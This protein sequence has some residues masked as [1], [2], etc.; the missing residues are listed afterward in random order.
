MKVSVARDLEKARSRFEQMNRPEN[1]GETLRLWLPLTSVL[2][3]THSPQRGRE[4][5]AHA[6]LECLRNN[7][8]VSIFSTFFTVV[9]CRDCR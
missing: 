9:S 8:T 5:G 4:D 1:S 7:K 6:L 3:N 2:R